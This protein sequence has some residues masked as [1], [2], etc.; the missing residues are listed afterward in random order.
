MA[1]SIFAD[2]GVKLLKSSE[3]AG[4]SS[5]SL[6][7]VIQEG[8]L[9]VL[10][11][12]RLRNGIKFTWFS[13]LKITVL[14]VISRMGKYKGFLYLF[15]HFKPRMNFYFCHLCGLLCVFLIPDHWKWRW[16]RWVGTKALQSFFWSSGNCHWIEGGSQDFGWKADHDKI[17]WQDVSIRRK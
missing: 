9:I 3:Q 13:D 10:H 7:F 5:N 12:E 16:R 4:K 15:K 11:Y 2:I 6:A 17:F 1:P 14:G 8:M